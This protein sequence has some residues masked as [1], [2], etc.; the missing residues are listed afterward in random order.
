MKTYLFFV[1][2]FLAYQKKY[3]RNTRPAEES[4]QI[5]REFMPKEDVTKANQINLLLIFVSHLLDNKEEN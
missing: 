4:K 5:L 1:C 2:Y 3:Y